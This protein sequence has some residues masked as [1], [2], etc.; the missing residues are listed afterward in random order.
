M[1]R[2]VIIFLFGIV[3]LGG[4]LRFFNISNNP[5]GL[6][7]DEVSIGLNAYD[8]LKTGKDQFGYTYP[9]AFKSFGD[10]K[11][12]GYIYLVS[13]SMAVFGKSDF[14]VRF[15]SALAGTLTILIVFFLF[16]ELLEIDKQI[17]KHANNFALIGA[18][19]FAILPWHIQF[20]RGGFEACVA[21]FFYSLSLLLGIYYLKA[22]KW[23]YLLGVILF[24]SFSEYTYHAYRIISPLTIF[25]V[26]IVAF[27]KDKKVFKNFLIA[28]IAFIAFSLPLIAFSLTSQGQERLLGTSALS[29]NS[30]FIG[31]VKDIIVYINNYLSYL[32]LTFLFHLGDQITRHQVQNFGLLYLW[33]LPFCI[34]GIYFLTKTKNTLLRFA[35]IFLFLVAP[36]APAI[37]LP[38]PHTLRFLLGTIPFT[39]LTVLGLYQVYIQ[40]NR[41]TKFILL[42][43]I[44]SI[45]LSFAY[46]LDYY[47]VQ[48]PKESQI[49]WGSGCKQVAYQLKQNYT[50]YDNIVIDKNLGCVPEY[51]SFYVPSAT[52][53]FV[54]GSWVKPKTPENKK[55]LYIRP[56]Y[57]NNKPENLE[58]NVYLGN[59]NHDIFAQFYSL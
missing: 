6:Y 4:F 37:A 47:Y 16:K 33:Q 39:L 35:V 45:I 5:P 18:A 52:V 28:F 58:E 31:Y 43:T 46:F 36:I 24:L 20:S 8:I 11:M 7:T 10:Y 25:L 32:S 19:I 40:R 55:V 12:P 48:Y 22:K 54:G 30:G 15:P 17:K 26:T 3:L 42:I 2:I 14:S 13:A 29:Q 38:S 49:D 9:L 27:F 23:P 50:K 53:Q 57:G 56:F 59:V 51:Y 1:K 41:L 34:A 21:L 44:I